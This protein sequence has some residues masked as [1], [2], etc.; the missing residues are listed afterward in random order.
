MTNPV[1]AT[2]AKQRCR[3]ACAPVFVIRSLD[4]ILTVAEQA[5]LSPTWSHAPEDSFSRDG[6]QIIR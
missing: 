3:S 2:F 5:S 4:S 6:A 1:Y